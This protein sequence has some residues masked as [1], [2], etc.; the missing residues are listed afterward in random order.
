MIKISIPSQIYHKKPKFMIRLSTILGAVATAGI[1]TAPVSAQVVIEPTSGFSRTTS[2]VKQTV[3]T[4]ITETQ[5]SNT[6]AGFA[7]AGDNLSVSDPG[8]R[9]TPESSYVI[10]QPGGQFNLGINRFDAGAATSVK[11]T[12]QESFTETHSRS[13][14]VFQ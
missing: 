5:Y 1:L 14:T 12:G 4:N 9:V 7:V 6:G 10:Y 11:V 13:F 3:N 8:G 2:C